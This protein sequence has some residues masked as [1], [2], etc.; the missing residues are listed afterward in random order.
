[1]KGEMW[2]EYAYGYYFSNKGRVKK[3]YKSKKVRYLSTKKNFVI[4]KGKTVS[5]PRT[6]YS[7][8]V[9][10]IPQGVNVYHK[11]GI[12]TDNNIVNLGLC[13]NE[14]LGKQFGGMSRARAV[15]DVKNDRYYRSIRSASKKLFLCRN[16]I[17][18]YCDGKTKK[19]S[20]EL[21][22]AEND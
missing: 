18:D 17:T 2:K 15:Y 21:R 7:M 12:K 5:V 16:S 1:M 11:N 19:Q 4:I 9:E 13:N 3:I 14:F 10:K 8:F 22:W 6:V 20:Y